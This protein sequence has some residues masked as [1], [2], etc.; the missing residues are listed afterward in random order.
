MPSLIN[1]F[2]SQITPKQKKD[3]LGIYKDYLYFERGL[4]LAMQTNSTVGLATM[5]MDQMNWLNGIDLRWNFNYATPS[6]QD[7]YIKFVNGDIQT[8]KQYGYMSL[9]HTTKAQDV[10]HKKISKCPSDYIYTSID[11]T[12][13]CPIERYAVAFP[14]EQKLKDADIIIDGLFKI[15]FNRKYEDQG[16]TPL[17]D[18]LGEHRTEKEFKVLL[19]LLEYYHRNMYEL[20]TTH[21]E[22]FSHYVSKIMMKM[23]ASEMLSGFENKTL[24]LIGSYA[25]K[26]Q[27]ILRVI[28]PKTSTKD[29]WKI[30]E[31]NNLITSAENMQHY[32]NIRN[33]LRHQWD[34]LDG[35]SKFAIGNNNKNEKSREENMASYHL[36]MDRPLS[37]RIKEY[38]KITQQLQPLLKILY[39]EFIVRETG[40]SNT[41]FVQRI[42]LWKQQNPDKTP[43]ITGNYLLRD[44][45]HTALVN[46]LKKVVPTAQ[47]WDDISVKDLNKYSH[48]EESYFNRTS[49][50][51]MYN[52]MESDV[53]NFCKRQGVIPNPVD[54]WKFIRKNILT[55]EEYQKWFNYRQL[56]NKL[57]HNHFNDELKNEVNNTIEQFMQDIIQI[58]QKT[59]DYEQT[60]EKATGKSPD[61]PQIIKVD[62][63]KN[64]HINKAPKIYP[65]KLIYGEDEILE[66]RLKDGTA[67]DLKHKKVTLPDNTRIY[68]DAEDF[69]VFKFDNGNK[70][71][72]DKTF[73]IT[74]FLERGRP[75]PV[76]RNENFITAPK[77]KVRTD[78]RSR[79]AED[80][81]IT[82][83]TK[84]VTQFNYA[85]NNAV[86][87]FSD[88]TQLKTTKKDFIVSHNNIVL[89]YDNRHAFKQSYLDDGT[90]PP[91]FKP[92]FSR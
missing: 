21:A 27:E 18:V 52:R 87:T 64:Y 14:S 7:D 70:L 62:T 71:F 60:Q 17:L 44:S 19:G 16:D 38:Q 74:K 58:Y 75:T 78:S 36:L 31:K 91:P 2:V 34:S 13:P 22:D 89:S 51:K 30:A 1:I 55:K 66:C 6:E 73:A 46:N 92:P 20:E 85:N 24:D 56:R 86:M 88:G 79:I 53:T 43:L 59:A 82:T 37:E 11:L 10:A 45:K 61:A 50:L 9:Y 90:P 40:E 77:H 26:T 49:F 68:F 84:L 3:L 69:N 39:P 5:F 76:S 35:T 28:Y 47:V 57:S 81:I 15:S 23:M 32:L 12:L 42:K 65:V 4:E 25:D 29:L 63:K 54:V 8:P 48:M 33:L 83:D 80:C 72:T 67:I 41:K